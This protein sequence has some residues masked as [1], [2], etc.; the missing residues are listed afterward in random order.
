MPDE[1]EFFRQP[2]GN[3][4]WCF[5]RSRAC[6]GWAA[7]ASWYQDDTGR[8]GEPDDKVIE[9]HRVLTTE[10]ARLTRHYSELFGAD[11]DLETALDL[12]DIE[13]AAEPRGRY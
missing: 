1:H 9:M 11:V 4:P 3:P 5:C 10:L 2:R 6:P 7:Y 8:A 12:A 13:K